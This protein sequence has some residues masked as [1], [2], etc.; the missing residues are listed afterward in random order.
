VESSRQ[1]P[2]AGH[3]HTT[4]V[5]PMLGGQAVVQS[6][7]RIVLAGRR[8]ALAG[9][10]AML[11]LL[12]AVELVRVSHG[13]GVASLPDAFQSSGSRG[14]ETERLAGNAAGD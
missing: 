12:A 1:S 3:H 11:R 14:C 8:I 9:R 10:I 2:R 13:L 5:F 4:G 6:A 7:G